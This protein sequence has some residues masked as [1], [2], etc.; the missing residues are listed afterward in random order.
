[1]LADR[2]RREGANRGFLARYFFGL[3]FLGRDVNYG[4]LY[5]VDI[6]SDHETSLNRTAD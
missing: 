6:E 4:F 5:H 2:P 3:T 1:M